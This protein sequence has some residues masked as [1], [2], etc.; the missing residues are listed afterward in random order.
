MDLANFLSI[1]FEQHEA[2]LD[3]PY[4]GDDAALEEAFAIVDGD[5]DAEALEAAFIEARVTDA[6]EWDVRFWEQLSSALE[7]ADI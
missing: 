4:Q 6:T 2:V 5:F 3:E 7:E 1:F